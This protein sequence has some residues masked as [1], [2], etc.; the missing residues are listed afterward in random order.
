MN[1][2]PSCNTYFRGC[3]SI[4]ARDAKNA[5]NTWRR[6]TETVENTVKKATEVYHKHWDYRHIKN[7]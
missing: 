3:G 7:T 5:S 1:I 2:Q 4:K 6:T